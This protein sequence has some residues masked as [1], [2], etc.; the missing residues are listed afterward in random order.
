LGSDLGDETMITAMDVN[1]I[2]FSSSS[3]IV[4]SSKFENDDNKIN[5]FF[6]V[7]VIVKHAKV[8]TLFDNGSEVNCIF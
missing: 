7:R 8:D 6:H 3:S 1:G 5:E 4:Q 2:S